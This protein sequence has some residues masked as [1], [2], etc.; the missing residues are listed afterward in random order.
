MA[1]GHRQSRCPLSATS[2]QRVPGVGPSATVYW[3]IEGHY[4]SRLVLE[5]TGHSPQHTVLDVSRQTHIV[6]YHF[7]LFERFPLRYIFFLEYEFL[8]VEGNT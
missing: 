1:S 8:L 4:L 6:I 3:L 5:Y 2:Q 7:V